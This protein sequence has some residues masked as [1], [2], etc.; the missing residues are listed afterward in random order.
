MS[1]GLLDPAVTKCWPNFLDSSR[2]EAQ[3]SWPNKGGCCA[4]LGL[5]SIRTSPPSFSLV[6]FSCSG[7]HTRW[8]DGDLSASVLIVFSGDSQ[9]NSPPPLFSFFFSFHD[10]ETITRRRAKPDFGITIDL[11]SSIEATM[12]AAFNGT[13]C[14]PSLVATTGA[15]R[16]ACVIC[17]VGEVNWRICSGSAFHCRSFFPIDDM[18]I[19]ASDCGAPCSTRGGGDPIQRLLTASTLRRRSKPTQPFFPSE[20]H[21]WSRE[22]KPQPATLLFDSVPSS[23]VAIAGAL[24]VCNT[25]TLVRVIGNRTREPCSASDA[26]WLPILARTHVFLSDT[27]TPAVEGRCCLFLYFQFTKRRSPSRTCGLDVDGC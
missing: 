27:T 9:R 14:F 7:R 1:V 3:A 4:G 12:K 20:W 2:P 25:P 13:S 11:A 22:G 6:S 5:T 10:V 16:R 15:E 26:R 24:V 8:T 19:L 18:H 23:F 17:V 21:F